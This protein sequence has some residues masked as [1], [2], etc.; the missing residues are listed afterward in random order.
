MLMLPLLGT[1]KGADGVTVI[2]GTL[3]EIELI[4]TVPAAVFVNETCC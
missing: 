2:H 3:A 1:T 4:P